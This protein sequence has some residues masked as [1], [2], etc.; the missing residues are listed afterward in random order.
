MERLCKLLLVCLMI[1]PLNISEAFGETKFSTDGWWKPAEPPFS[2]C[3]M[4]DASVVFRYKAPDAK[5]VTLLFDE[6]SMRKIPMVKDSAGVWSVHL[7]DVEPRLYQYKFLVDGI[8]TIDPANP[9]VKAG[10]M[11]YGSVVEIPGINTKRF[12]ELQYPD[13]GEIHTLT[14]QSTPLGMIRRMNVYVPREAIM[15]PEQKFPVLYLRHGGGDNENSWINDGKAAIIM[16]NLIHNNEA[17]P[18]YVVMTNGLTDGSWAGGSTPEGI[19]T[20]EEE[21]LSDVIPHIESRYNVV[22]EKRGRAIAG[23]SMGGGQAYVIGLR[24]LDKFCA[25]GE[26]SSGILS[27]SNFDYERYAPGII[28]NPQGIN[29]A[30]E[31][32][33]ISCGTL[34]N[35]YDGH[36]D[37]IR[38]LKG[39]NVHF[40][41]DEMEYG[42]EWQFWRLQLKEFASRIFKNL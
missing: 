34:D 3:V 21:L 28:S 31:L 2:P 5:S 13:G 19:T 18:M 37:L 39:R 14:Y 27:D 8:E 4:D 24:N 36:R 35:R 32:L 10:T 22:A 16:D 15:H 17:T 23:L 33:W 20:L 25:I 1:F 26:F 30:L 6:W 41:Y 38:D 9:V 29:D 12:D 42:H 11:V 40:E 7:Y